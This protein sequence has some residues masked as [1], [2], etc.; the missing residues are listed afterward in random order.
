M[1]LQ[2]YLYCLYLYYSNRCNSKITI[3]TSII[4]RAWRSALTYNHLENV[5]ARNLI[6]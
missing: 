3:K 2:I 6:F 1:Y 5:F 4:G